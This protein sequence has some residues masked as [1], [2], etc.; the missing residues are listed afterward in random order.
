MDLKESP[1]ILFLVF[2][3]VQRPRQSFEGCI[4][5]VFYVFSWPSIVLVVNCS[6]SS[7]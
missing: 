1:F 5:N 2:F 3:P 4:T 7:Q 6:L